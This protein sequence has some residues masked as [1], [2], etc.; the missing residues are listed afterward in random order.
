[1]SQKHFLSFKN[2]AQPIVREFALAVGRRRELIRG[3]AEQADSAGPH[4]QAAARLQALPA[5]QGARGQRAKERSLC[6]LRSQ[7]KNLPA[8]PL[9]EKTK[10][11]HG[12]G[13]ALGVVLPHAVYSLAILVFIS[14]SIQSNVSFF[15]NSFDT[16]TVSTCRM[17]EW[18][19][20]VL[21]RALLALCVA[22]GGCNFALSAK[23]QPLDAA[24]GNGGRD[25]V[26][27]ATHPCMFLLDV[28]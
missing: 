4:V 17:L 8:A 20:A 11:I 27:C 13:A 28:R 12:E 2:F 26:H 10:L 9:L 1:M 6:R 7:W 21:C 25:H 3:K 15:F 24:L 19:L 14:E 5:D 18:R 23:S 22:A 16:F